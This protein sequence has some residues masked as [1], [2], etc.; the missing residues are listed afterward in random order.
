MEICQVWYFVVVVVAFFGNTNPHVVGRR[1]RGCVQRC[2]TGPSRT[3]CHQT[4]PF[5]R[6][7]TSTRSNCPPAKRTASRWIPSSGWP[8]T[9]TTMRSKRSLIGRIVMCDWIRHPVKARRSLIGCIVT[10]DWLLHDL[11]AI[12]SLIGHGIRCDWIRYPVSEDTHDWT[13]YYVWLNT[14]SSKI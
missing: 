4:S 7:E 5:T 11:R 1:W 8:S 9:T 10:C 13:H 6:R 14:S 3:P 2:L 12:H